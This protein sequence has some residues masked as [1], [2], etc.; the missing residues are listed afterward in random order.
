ML[1]NKF[2]R[3]K[4]IIINTSLVVISATLLITGCSTLQSTTTGQSTN[5]SSTSSTSVTTVTPSAPKPTKKVALTFDVEPTVSLPQYKGLEYKPGKT[6]ATK[7]EIDTEINAILKKD[8]QMIIKEEQVI[9][10]NDYATFDFVGSV[11]GVEFEGGKAEN[12][13]LQIGSGQFI[14]GFEDQMIGMAA[15]ETK[16]L[17]VKFPKNYGQKDLAGKAA[18]FNVTVH[19]VKEEKLPELT[20]E[21]VANLNLEGITTVKQLKADKKAKIEAQ[22]VISE[23]DRQVDEIINKIF[24]T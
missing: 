13:E 20:D 23:K 2:S 15:G 1:K 3:L 8:A 9:A 22:K 16:D 12:Y 11:D 10:K 6:N 19:E 24:K 5:I 7:K 18:V 17:N 4:K 14:P 21:Y